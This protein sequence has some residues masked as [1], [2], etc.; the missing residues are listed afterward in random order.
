MKLRPKI[1][2]IFKITLI[3][4]TVFYIYTKL[5]IYK[6]V[7]LEEKHEKLIRLERSLSSPSQA[8]DD[9]L[10]HPAIFIGG[11]MSSGTSLLRS[12]LDVHPAVKCG[13]ETK[14]IQLIFDLMKDIRANDHDLYDYTRLNGVKNET[15]DK[16]VG[17]LLYY[18]MLT[19]T[20]SNVERLCNKEP[21]NRMHIEY[22]RSIFPNSKFIYIIRDGRETSYSL[23][24]RTGNKITFKM[25]YSLLLKWNEGNRDSYAQCLRTGP[26]YCFIVRYE[27]LVKSP[28]SVLRNLM[29]FLNLPWIDR[30]LHHEEYVG[31]EIKMS[32]TEWS[33]KGI[34]KKIFDKSL[35]NWLGNVPN[36]N[37]QLVNQ[38]I[39]MLKVFNFE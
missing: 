16:S 9:F 6:N 20:K 25:F 35:K 28:E 30:L 32:K 13:P 17:L 27:T 2:N 15:I 11:S 7:K 29:E 26:D 12:I 36:Y 31:S 21:S 1:H 33:A 37:E 10:Q 22:I 18:L 39:D 23:L 4:L 38:N 24:K 3:V 19:N 34:K 14:F 8:L 5:T